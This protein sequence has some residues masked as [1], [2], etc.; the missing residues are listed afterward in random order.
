MSSK[1][2]KA[3]KKSRLQMGRSTDGKKKIGLPSRR[4][5]DKKTSRPPPP[6]SVRT[7]FSPGWEVPAGRRPCSSAYSWKNVVDSSRKRWGKPEGMPKGEDLADTGSHGWS[8]GIQNTNK[9]IWKADRQRPKKK[10]SRKRV[11]IVQKSQKRNLCRGSRCKD[12][13]IP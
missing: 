1:K 4:R 9:K 5:D 8:T 3:A 13:G 6:Q 12:I 10:Q 11:S 2:E 7:R